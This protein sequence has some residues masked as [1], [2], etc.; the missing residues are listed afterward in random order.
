MGRSLAF[1]TGGP[2]SQSRIVSR[3]AG[4]AFEGMVGHA[5]VRRMSEDFQEDLVVRDS[6]ESR[7]LR[8]LRVLN[9]LV[10]KRHGL[11]PPGDCRKGRQ[12][13]RYGCQ[14][15][16]GGSKGKAEQ[17]ELGCAGGWSARS[18]GRQAMH[19]VAPQGSPDRMLSSPSSP[20]VCCDPASWRTPAEQSVPGDRRLSSNRPPVSQHQLVSCM[21]TASPSGRVRPHAGEQLVKRVRWRSRSRDDGESRST[22]CQQGQ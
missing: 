16:A 18:P 8:S 12:E 19:E 7:Y 10:G 2:H 1:R 17:V 4:P 5:V 11:G 14:M 15:R 22:D 21:A 13:T 3:S 9:Q 20:L 6:R